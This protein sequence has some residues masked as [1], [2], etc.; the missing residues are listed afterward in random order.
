MSLTT[1]LLILGARPVV[2][3]PIAGR[4]AAVTQTN[5]K[6]P[7][8]TASTVAFGELSFDLWQSF[9]AQSRK[10]ELST[11]TSFDQFFVSEFGAA[12]SS[13]YDLNPSIVAGVGF[14]AGA[15]LN[16][17]WGHTPDNGDP[18]CEERSWMLAW[19]KTSGQLIPDQ[20]V[21]LPEPPSLILLTMGLLWLAIRVRRK[22][23]RQKR[24]GN[25]N[26]AIS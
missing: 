7:E 5:T 26:R 6:D 22:L 3:D 17:H 8:V 1:T 20:I 16:S 18:T 4:A 25:L 11:L 10:W 24:T 13:Q 14:F 21:A 23:S 15:Y 12:E 2:A 19:D 9:I